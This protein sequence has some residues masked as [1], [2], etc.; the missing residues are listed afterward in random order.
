MRFDVTMDMTGPIFR[1]GGPNLDREIN[2]AVKE[3]VQMGELRLALKFRPQG[4]KNLG[5]DNSG[6][7]L[8]KAQA[9]PGQASD[10]N[11]RKNI[12]TT[13]E[14]LGGVIEDGNVI[15]GPWL[16]GASSRNQRTRFKGYAQ[17]RMTKQYLQKHSKK[18]FGAYIQR[19]VRRMNA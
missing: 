2:G 14:N 7:F 4:S 18:V 10:G 16:E 1:A 15:Y 19:F 13:F 11:Y 12:N 6:V 8:T 5:D 17:F 3:L 9:L